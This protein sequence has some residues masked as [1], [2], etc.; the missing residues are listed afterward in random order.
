MNQSTKLV[1][2]LFTLKTS[3][4][5]PEVGLGAM[6]AVRNLLRG[7]L[8]RMPT[9]Q[10]VA[11]AIKI[12]PLTAKQLEAVASKVISPP[13]KESQ[14]DVLRSSGFSKRT[15][16]WYYILAEAA[17]HAKGRHLGPVGSTLIAEVLIGLVEKS[18]NSILR[19]QFWAPTL[20]STKKGTFTLADLLRFADVLQV[21]THLTQRVAT[22]KVELF[23]NRLKA[24]ACGFAPAPPQLTELQQGIMEGQSRIKDGRSSA[25]SLNACMKRNSAYSHN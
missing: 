13:G 10:A 4:G 14:V 15:P 3:T 11:K 12:K 17:F 9:G 19:T 5:Q 23:A 2:P 24:Q 25:W 16:L 6:L 8:L 21:T 7:Y 1:N 22:W 20:P 18:E